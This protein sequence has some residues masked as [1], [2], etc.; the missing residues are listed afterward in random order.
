MHVIGTQNFICN[1]IIVQKVKAQ[2]MTRFFQ[3]LYLLNKDARVLK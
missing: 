1:C 3:K 2:F